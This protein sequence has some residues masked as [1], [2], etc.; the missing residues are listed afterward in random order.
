M[1]TKK[2]VLWFAPLP[3]Y[4]AVDGGKQTIYFPVIELPKYC[5]A[6]FAFLHDLDTAELTKQTV[7]FEQHGLHVTPLRLNTR[8]G[9]LK[10]LRSILRGQPFKYSKYHSRHVLQA[11]ADLIR[12]EQFDTIVF[13]TA[14]LCWY[15]QQLRPQ[16]PHITMNL[17][18][19][20][21]D[22]ELFHQFAMAQRNLL[23][24]LLSLGQSLLTRYH[25]PRIWAAMDKVVFISDADAQLAKQCRY[26]D[27]VNWAVSYDGRSHHRWPVADAARHIIF[28]G[29]LNTPQN[30]TSL[31]DFVK[32]YWRPF[33]QTQSADIVALHITGNDDAALCECLEID[34]AQLAALNIRALGFVDNLAQTIAEHALVLSPTTMGVGIRVKVVEAMSQGALVV[35]SPLDYAMC[36]FFRDGQNVITYHNYAEFQAKVTEILTNPAKAQAIR[37]QAFEDAKTHF[38]WQ[39]LIDQILEEK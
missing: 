24:K 33:N 32:Q 14:H 29:A 9:I 10:M 39:N 18:A 6:H 27:R 16:F 34:K 17:R 20:T 4:P 22:Y 26:F 8:D 5:D 31:R 36:S 3:V 35:L 13:S 2:K 7:H 1:Q 28:P 12:R 37:H 11:L 38:N 15:A 21:V 30:R 19:H 25:E 23:I